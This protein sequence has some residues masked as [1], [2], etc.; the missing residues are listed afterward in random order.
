MNYSESEKCS[1]GEWHP[2]KRW[3][4]HTEKFLRRTSKWAKFEPPEMSKK[5]DKEFYRRVKKIKKSDP[6]PGE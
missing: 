4:Y 5:L 2:I 6:W 3:D 1:A